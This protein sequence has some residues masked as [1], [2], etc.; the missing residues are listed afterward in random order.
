MSIHEDQSIMESS[1]SDFVDSHEVVENESNDPVI[2]ERNEERQL[3]QTQHTQQRQQ[4]Q[5]HSQRT[6]QQR[7]TRQRTSM[8]PVDPRHANSR[9]FSG[10]MKEVNIDD[11]TDEE[12]TSKMNMNQNYLDVQLIRLIMPSQRDQKVTLYT[13]INRNGKKVLVSRECLLDVFSFVG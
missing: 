3:Q 11:L 6:Q 5:Q 8:V 4:Q 1:T 12:K 13:T 9:L 7:T 2:Q 10:R